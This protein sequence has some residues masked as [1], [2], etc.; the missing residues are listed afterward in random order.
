LEATAIQV[1]L[2]GKLVKN[3]CGLP[4]AFPPTEQ[5]GP[6]RLFRR[7]IA[8]LM[9]GDPN[10]K[11]VDWNSRLSTRGNSCVIMATKTPVSS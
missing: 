9:A 7:G 5:S 6:V 1:A 8:G 3:L 11:N 10:A 4:L 2:A